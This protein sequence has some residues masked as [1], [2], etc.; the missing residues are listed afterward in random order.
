MN[1]AVFER[2][3]PPEVIHLAEVLR[4]EPGKRDVLVR[5]QASAVTSGDSRIR[6]ARFPP[7]FAPMVRLI[8]GIH[9]PRR[10]ILGDTFAGVVDAVGAHVSGIAVGEAVCGMTGTKLGTHSQY[11]VARADNVA[12]IP[13]GVS[14]D[15]AAG[16]V[17]GGTAA[18]FFLR[19]KASVSPGKSV[20]INGAS[21]AVGTNAVQLAK[22]FGA[23]VT[24]VTSPANA[25]LVTHLGADRVVDSDHHNLATDNGRF[26]VVLDC[27]GNLMI[28]SGRRLLAE[29]GVLVLL[30]A[31]LWNTIRARGNVVAGAA[32]ERVADIE[33]LLGLVVAGK[34][35]VVH[36]RSYDLEHIV[37]A[38]RYVDTGQKIGNVIVHPWSPIQ[39]EKP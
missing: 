34:L 33:F 17:F 27:V 21:G 26:D 39:K 16:L 15:E 29:E 9:R 2:Y 7:G 35:T 12:S 28:T 25:E 24:A 13:A 10:R 36:D 11:V 37:D 1:A 6:G 30:V 3:G 23:N 38:H 19:D 5:V 18:L 20:L 14:F 32:P 8:I 22:H 31:S 4:P